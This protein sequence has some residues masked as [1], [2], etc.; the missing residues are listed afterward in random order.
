MSKT[1][2]E[3]YNECKAKLRTAGIEDYVFESK[4]IIKHITGLD[5]TQILTRYNDTL[6]QFQE[7]NLT[8]IIKQRTVHYPLQYIIGEWSFYGNSF[9]VG[10]GVLIP[11]A[12]TETIIDVSKDCIGDNKAPEILDLCTGSGCI[13]ITLA[14]LFPE[15]KVRMVEKYDTASVYAW[16]NINRLEVKNAQLLEGDVLLGDANDDV[17]DLIVSNPPYI[18]E[19]EMKTVSPEVEYEPETALIAGDDGLVFYRA[20]VDNYKGSLKAGGTMAFEVGIGEAEAVCDIMHRA[21]FEGVSTQ[22]DMNGIDRVVFG[23]APTV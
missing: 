22:K 16:K 6:T 18:P 23:T 13:G 3:A 12:D 5:N 2:F 21:G 14:L 7:D 4:Q 17:Y 11:R 19:N 15:A 8:V 9:V 1:I 10:P 20:I